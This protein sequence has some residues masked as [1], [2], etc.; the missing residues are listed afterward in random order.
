MSVGRSDMYFRCFE[1]EEELVEV[2]SSAAFAT[3][4]NLSHA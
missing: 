3:E 4:V 2:A 1:K